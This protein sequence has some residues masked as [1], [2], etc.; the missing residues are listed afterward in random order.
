MKTKHIIP[1]F[2]IIGL[3]LSC[4][5]TKSTIN[6]DDKLVGDWS[7]VAEATP[8][9]DV[10]ITMTIAKDEAG[11]FIGALT[12]MM[13]DYTMS[14]LVLEHGKLSCTFDVQG[15]LFEFQGVFIEDEFKGQTIGPAE[16]YVT[17]G[18]RKG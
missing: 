3:V 2:L 6:P 17:N 7:L 16:S 4:G 12:S 8:Q 5:S 11:N 13:G 1:L 18:K 9:G 14:N 15:I 10:P